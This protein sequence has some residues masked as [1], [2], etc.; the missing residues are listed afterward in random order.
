M[1]SD[2]ESARDSESESGGPGPSE[3]EGTTAIHRPCTGMMM[4]A[5]TPTR[6]PAQSR[7]AEDSERASARRRACSVVD[8][9]AAA[10]AL[11]DSELSMGG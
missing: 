9:A 8:A 10:G 4:K 6:R 5:R 11:S 1:G 2:S 7:A 3:P